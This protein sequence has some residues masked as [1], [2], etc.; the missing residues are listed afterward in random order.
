MVSHEEI[1]KRHAQLFGMGMAKTMYGFAFRGYYVDAWSIENMPA[2][3]WER[4]L[5]DIRKQNEELRAQLTLTEKEIAQAFV[6]YLKTIVAPD[7]ME[8][9]SS[10]TIDAVIYHIQSITEWAEEE[11]G[12]CA[13]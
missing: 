1:K 4:Y 13:Q 10:E 3:E 6:S 8:R 11:L 12:K 7:L 2:E 9:D 5:V